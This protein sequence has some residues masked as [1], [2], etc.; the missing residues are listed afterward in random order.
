[1]DF[2]GGAR[3]LPLGSQG[4]GEEVF[5]LGGDCLLVYVCVSLSSPLEP[6][7]QHEE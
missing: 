2:W 4:F 7:P 6:S 5:F 1:M 3:I